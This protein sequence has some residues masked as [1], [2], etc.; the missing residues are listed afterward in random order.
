[1]N[2][3]PAGA[4]KVPLEG[5]VLRMVRTG[6]QV[7]VGARLGEGGQ[8]VVHEAYFGGFPCAVKWYRSV[9]K[10]TELRR[11]IAALAERGRPHGSFIWPIDVVVSDQQPG[12][13]YVMPRLEPGFISFA[14]L[15]GRPAQP[16]FRAMITIGRHLVAA[17]EALHASGLC[18]RDISFGNL[19]VDPEQAD[20]AIID[21]DNVGLDGGD[22]FVWGTLRFM[23]PEVVRREAFPSSVT[24][25]YSLAVFLF[26]LFVH[27]HPLEGIR[28]EATFSWG[29]QAP[30]S[31]GDLAV[32]YFGTEPLF[33]FDPRDD[34]NRPL[35]GDPMNTWWPIYPRFFREVFERA[36]TAG[37]ADTAGTARVS[38]G[39][40]RRSLLRL[41]DCVSVCPCKASVFHDPDAPAAPC[42]NC[43]HVPPR[44]PV[45]QLPGGTVVLSEGGVVTGHHLRRDRDYDTVVGAVETHPTVPGQVVLRNVGKEA[46]TMKPEDEPP[47]RVEP[48]RRLGVRPMTIDFGAVR[49][50]I[51]G[52]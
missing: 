15:L 3:G 35:P 29:S 13:G 39:V 50:R 23:A 40:W 9:P 7:T 36:F 12:F 31:E 11:S 21:N 32:R 44:P 16:P 25:L 18:Y 52:S 10:P 49:G 6:T 4:D 5:M 14:Q 38:E 46:W 8:G 19:W 22:V 27:G 41:A 24:D 1:M 34:S 30:E 33:V 45:L 28:T 43:G 48:A 51:L 42:W 26:Y 37:L 2:G 17:F 20:V 47:K